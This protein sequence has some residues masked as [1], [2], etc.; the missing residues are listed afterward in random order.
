MARI[1]VG[2]VA[3]GF[4]LEWYWVLSRAASGKY[5]TIPVFDGWPGPTPAL[6][7]ALFA[8]SLGSSVAMIL[9]IADGLPAILV[10]TSGA[11]VLLTDQ[12]TYSNHL[13]LLISLAVVLG[14]SGA[15]KAWSLSRTPRAASVPYW[16]A[17]L[18]KAQVT[19]LYAWTAIAKIN[20]QYLSGEVLGIHLQPWV[21]IPDHLL[22]AAAL[23]S[24][25]TEAFLAVALWIPMTRK[26]AFV[27]GAGLHLGIVVLLQSPAPLIGFGMLMFAGYI[28]FAWSRP[29]V[30]SPT[31]R[32]SEGSQTTT[33]TAGHS[34]P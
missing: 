21:P 11:V 22:P 6:V 32:S 30:S 34:A 29:I 8:V 3:A 23:L 2:L 7:S 4:S 1:L 15:A 31:T 13:V 20:P 14:L 12:Q 28:L 5:L 18:I 24:I 17:L 26:L 10:G 19:T 9:G 27:I 33:L 25:L 16:P